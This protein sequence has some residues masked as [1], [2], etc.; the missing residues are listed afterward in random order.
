[1]R[2]DIYI[3]YRCPRKWQNDYPVPTK[4]FTI[5]PDAVFEV[6]GTQYFLEVDRMQK[7]NVNIEKLNKYK[8]FRDTN[9]WQMYNG[10]KFPVI[11]FYV[12]KDSRK[13]QLMEKNPGLELLVLTKEDL[14]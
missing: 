11:L 2:N 1:M 6:N 3:H 4:E 12:T 14:R 7:L 10:G 8:R 13:H 5:V 9:M